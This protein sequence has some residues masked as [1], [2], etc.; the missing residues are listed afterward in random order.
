MARKQPA[1]AVTAL[2]VEFDTMT[3]ADTGSDSVRH[4]VC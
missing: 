2:T 1:M 4:N 3:G